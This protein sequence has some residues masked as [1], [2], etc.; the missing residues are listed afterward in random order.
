MRKS[1]GRDPRSRVFSL[2]VSTVFW[3]TVSPSHPDITHP[4][5]LRRGFGRFFLR[6]ESQCSSQPRRNVPEEEDQTDAGVQVLVPMVKKKKL[7]SIRISYF[8]FS[9]PIRYL[10]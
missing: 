10:P 6:N 9:S 2:F 8:L 4:L 7:Y 5:G 1:L 3:L